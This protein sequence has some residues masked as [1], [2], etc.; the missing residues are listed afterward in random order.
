MTT[1][2]HSHTHS[3]R[4]HH[5]FTIIETHNATLNCLLRPLPGDTHYHITMRDAQKFISYGVLVVYSL[6]TE[7]QCPTQ[8]PDQVCEYRWGSS[9]QNINTI[10]LT[11]K[12]LQL[13]HVCDNH[14]GCDV[15]SDWPNLCFTKYDLHLS[16]G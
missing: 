13:L 15:I 8:R 14:A 12:H 10:L 1:R 6:S 11:D 7:H 5:K 4:L 3:T 9:K 2:Q 16:Y